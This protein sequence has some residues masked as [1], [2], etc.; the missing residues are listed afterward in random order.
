MTITQGGR[1]N[2]HGRNAEN[3]I[4]AILAQWVTK[5]DRQVHIGRSIFDSEVY[6]DFFIRNHPRFPTGLIVE[7]KWQDASGSVDEKLPYLVMNI[8]FCYPCPTIIVMHGGGFRP[9][10][11]RWLRTQLDDK[12]I[13]VFRLEEFLSWCNR[14]L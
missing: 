4:A 5:D 8:R 11:V 14:T 2:R 3:V 12:L 13:A 1:A 7:S 10:A 6:A 9:G